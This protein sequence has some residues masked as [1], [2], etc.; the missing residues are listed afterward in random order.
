[1]ELTAAEKI[2]NVIRTIPAGKIVSYGDLGVY[3]GIS[4]KPQHAAKATANL[5]LSLGLDADSDT[6][7]W[8]V[9]MNGGRVVAAGSDACTLK[10]AGTWYASIIIRM[11]NDG[12][13][14]L[15]DGRVDMEKARWD[16]TS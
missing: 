10:E 12:I 7:W 15:P 16:F 13:P 14:F 4:D 6:P 1:M 3:V 8:K 9:C 5:I 2:R 11:V